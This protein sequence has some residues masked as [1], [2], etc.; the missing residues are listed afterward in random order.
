MIFI[1][2]ELYQYDD[3][4]TFLETKWNRLNSWLT[5]TSHLVMLRITDSKQVI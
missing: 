3:Y 4:L 1:G 2:S 5:G